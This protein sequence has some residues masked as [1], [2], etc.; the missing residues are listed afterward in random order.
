MMKGEDHLQRRGDLVKLLRSQTGGASLRHLAKELGVSERTIQRDFKTLEEAGYAIER[1]EDEYGKRFWRIPS[2]G[3]EDDGAAGEREEAPGGERGEVVAGQAAGGLTAEAGGRFLEGLQ[4]ILDKISR[5]VP[6]QGPDLSGLGETVYVRGE[7]LPDASVQA[8]VIR[9]LADAVRTHR[10]V[11]LTYRS[12]PEGKCYTTRFDP[13][14]LIHDDGNLY[15]VGR[16]HRVGAIRILKV[17]RI[18][19]AELNGRTFAL[20]DGF[21]MEEHFRLWFGLTEPLANA[22]EVVVKFTG[23]MVA[24]AKDRIWQE[25]QR[26]DWLPAEETRFERSGDAPEALVATFRL[27]NVAAFKQWIKGFADRAEVVRPTWLRRELLYELLATAR[28]YEG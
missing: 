16:C 20:P 8:E 11:E 26:S 14:G 19:A 23:P 1:E 28:Q 2:E 6:P 15:A 18:L 21:R 5:L 4:R 3:A 7:G 17:A 27:S 9:V 12:C 10:S 24:L 22:A 25:S 13:Y